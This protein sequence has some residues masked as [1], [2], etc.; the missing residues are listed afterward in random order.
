MGKYKPSRRLVLGGLVGGEP[1]CV[2][3]ITSETGLTRSQAYNA[4]FLCWK[5]G[6]VLRTAEPIYEREKVFKGRGGSSLH[7]RPFHLYI[8]RP[9]GVDE[10]EV[11]GCRFVGYADEHLD[12]RGGGKVSKA[13]RVLDFLREH[14]DGAFFSIEI[15]EGLKEFEVMVRDVMSNVRRFERKGLVYVRGYKTDERQTPFREGY[16]LTWLDPDKPRERAIEEAIGRTDSALVGRAS[17]SPL[18]ERVHRIRDMV[19]EHSKLRKLVSHKYLENK[20][21]L[22]VDM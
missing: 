4:L 8:L 2:R 19:L 20:L 15:V 1:K 7:T 5:R 12:P 16:L 3:E 9:D 10:V 21:G 13:R 22:R 14:C 6:L 18:M 11:G 17:S